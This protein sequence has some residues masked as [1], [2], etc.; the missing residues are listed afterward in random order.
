MRRLRLTAILLAV[1][2]LLA[3]CSGADQADSSAGDAGPETAAMDDAVDAPIGDADA[4]GG[5][6]EGIA[7]DAAA[8]P[9]E[10]EPV[11]D[12]VPVVERQGER[13]IKEG[14]MTVEVAED[15]YQRAFQRVV[16]AATSLGGAV[17][18]STTRT[19][20]DGATSGT[21]TVRVP[22]ASYE[23][24][25]ASTGEIGTVRSQDI[26]SQDVTAEFV[27]LEA[28]LRH[29]QAQEAFYLGLLEEADGVQDAIA[30]QQQ[31]A[32]IQ[33]R[34]EQ[35]RGRLNVL[36]DRTSFSTLTV[37]L[38]EPDTAS[39]LAGQE[40]GSLSIAAYVDRAERAFVTVVGWLIVL[41]G[42]TAPVLVPLLI[43][44]LA[45]RLFR[46]PE[47]APVAASMATDSD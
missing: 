4:E 35:L 41:A 14:S 7:G 8:E 31:L 22:V 26:T 27:D 33:E 47:P 28:R 44:A 19:T 1:G 46:R 30:V 20:D 10:G 29:E 25:L 5:G 17:V 11:P 9:V 15:G 42:A 38:V 21:V 16:S 2:L 6:A 34:I 40:P 39:V 18:S 24:L 43:A 36:D 23:D 3:A 13:I 32:G 45:W 37:E 12:A